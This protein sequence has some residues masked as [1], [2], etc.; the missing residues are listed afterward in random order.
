MAE[1]QTRTKGPNHGFSFLFLSFLLLYLWTISDQLKP[2]FDHIGPSLT[3][4]D[5]FEPHWT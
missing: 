4:K 5:N 3:I 2:V 1:D